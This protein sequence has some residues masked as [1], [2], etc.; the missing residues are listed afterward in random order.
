FGEQM[1]HDGP[2]TWKLRFDVPPSAKP[3]DYPISGLMGYMSCQFEEGKSNCERPSAVRFVGT[4]KVGDQ[5]SNSAA[6]LAFAAFDIYKKIAE[7]AAVFA[8]NF[9]RQISNAPPAAATP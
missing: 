7:A 9:D 6:P 3:G 1:Y 5:A 4:L 8:D 2:V